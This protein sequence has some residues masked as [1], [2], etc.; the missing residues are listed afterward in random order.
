MR[1]HGTLAATL[2]RARE[3]G[4]AARRAL[5]TFRDSPERKALDEVIEFCLE[6]GY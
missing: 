4:E 2:E 6:R 5:F 3:Y 1:R